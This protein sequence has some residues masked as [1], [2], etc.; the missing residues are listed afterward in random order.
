MS[1]TSVTFYIFLDLIYLCVQIKQSDIRL[2]ALSTE[3]RESI[4]HD[5]KCDELQPPSTT[6]PIED[7]NGRHTVHECANYA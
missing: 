1:I 4:Y 5:R 3:E 6:N 2:G 7:S